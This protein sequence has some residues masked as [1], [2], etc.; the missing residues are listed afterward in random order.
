[1]IGW[2]LWIQVLRS[3]ATS[4]RARSLA[5]SVFFIAEPGLAQKPRQ[6]SRVRRNAVTSLEFGGE[7]RHRDVRLLLHASDQEITIPRELAGAWRTALPLR[8]K[9]ARATMA[10]YQLHRERWAD[11]QI[12]GR[13]APRLATRDARHQ[14]T[15]QIQS[16]GSPHDP[17]PNTVNHSSLIWGIPDSDL[18]HDALGASLSRGPPTPIVMWGPNRSFCA[19][20]HAAARAGAPSCSHR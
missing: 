6:R 9:R 19:C 15:A 8:R 2:R 12:L 7:L 16:I 17:P 18:R 4:K 20:S 11:L 10:R 13:T 5:S 14:P 3:L 1:M